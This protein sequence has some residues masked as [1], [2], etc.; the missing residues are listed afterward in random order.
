MKNQKLELMWIGKENQPKVE[1]RVLIED[2]SK[3]YGDENT[4]NMLIHGDNLLA[5]KA[6]EDKFTNKI[7]CIY[8]D[9]PYNTG[10]AFEHYDDNLEHSIWLNLIKARIQILKNLLTTNGVICI[11]CDDSEQP[12][13]KVLCDEV[14]GRENFMTL[15]TVETG[16]VFGTK[17]SHID[18]TFVKVKDY[19]LIYVLNKNENF[20]INPLWTKTNELFDTHYS[21]YIKNRIKISLKDYLKDI[22][23]VVSDFKKF[24]LD[25]KLD[26]ISKLMDLDKKFKK[27]IN[28]EIAQY[29]YQ[30]QPYSQKLS[31]DILKL[32]DKEDI[33][34]YGELLLFKTS[35][36]S[37]RYYKSFKDA[38]HVTDDYE[39]EKCRSTARGDLWKNFHI[40]M[41]NINDEGFVKFKSGK[42][43]ERL[44]RDILYS[45]T[46]EGDI[47]L[48]S[49]LGS[50]TTCA[51]A[52]KMNRKW[53][54]I[55]LGE[56]CYTHCIPRLNNIID[57][58]DSTGI[59]KRVNWNGGGGYK[60]YELA[61]SL[62]VK[63]KFNNW[64]ISENYNGDLLAK[65]ICKQEKFDYIEKSETYWKQ[66]KSS[67][68]DYIFVTTNHIS[69]EYLDAIH[70]EMQENESLLICCKTY[71]EECEDRYDNVTIK[72]IP[73]AILNNCE[74]GKDDYSLNVKE[75]LEIDEDE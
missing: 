29:I 27:F 28:E 67:E 41:R 17:A 68:N 1:P 43:P 9:P 40:D 19:I 33:V 45:F 36:G 71:Q 42:K 52:H 16:E 72:K 58:N 11:H 50:G 4:E 8:I 18:K 20:R 70:D 23:W 26:N 66:G 39:Q 34:N 7:K 63:D 6:L 51:V 15:I 61:P 5:L 69:I 30:D 56:Q 74:Y 47:V 60:F 59:T 35:S 57:G 62:L 22:D 31:D 49:F 2:K 25:L 12:Y 44:I 73:Q 54:G 21:Y 10:S 55:E 13:L 37:V 48:D 24:N 32:L 38:I 53:I 65:A 14:F 46:N 75:V 64:I 3:S